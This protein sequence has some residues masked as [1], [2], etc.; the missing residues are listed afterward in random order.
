MKKAEIIFSN[1]QDL[2]QFKRGSEASDCQI[3]F[4]RKVLKGLFPEAELNLAV[5]V[6]GATV[7]E[8][9]TL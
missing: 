5:L 7:Q 3:D 6:F 4:D 9:L 1:L 8:P 2:C